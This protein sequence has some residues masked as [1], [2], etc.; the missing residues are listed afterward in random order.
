MLVGAI[1]V[2]LTIVAVGTV[3]F[4]ISERMG[5]TEALYATLN[6]VTTVGR[7]MQDFSIRGK[8][9]AMTVM[10]CGVV[11]ATIVLGLVT[12]VMVE[13]E[14]QSILG[15]RRM[16]KQIGRLQNH[17][18]LC[19]YGRMGRVIARE[20]AASRVPFVVIEREDASFMQS[21]ID[22]HLAVNGD[23]ASDEIL[24]QCGIANA[25]SLI[26]VT[27][28]D[29]DNVFVTLTARQLNPNLTVVGRANEDSSIEK[30]KRAGASRVFSP[31]RVGGRQMA[32]AALRPNV[33]DFLAE[34][35]EAPGAESYQIE[36][37]RVDPSA[38]VCGKS[39]RELNLSR[40]LG[41]IVIGLRRDQ[42]A[43]IYNPS[44]DARI[45][46]NDIMIA[47]APTTGLKQLAE[48]VGAKA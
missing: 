13:G 7:S 20:L 38:P 16:E 46:G 28:S 3:G 44:A 4:S 48:L 15:R 36:E 29:A 14:L 18:I 25:R 39:L 2:L 33:I 10:V 5:F 22:G 42:Q 19:G 9:V 41:V 8:I 21:Q 6:T 23:A 17:I 32:H 26:C 24:Q 45:E 31:Y 47:I 37:L 40:T 12:R 11:V 30:L 34:I 43:M 35:G 1:A 27:S